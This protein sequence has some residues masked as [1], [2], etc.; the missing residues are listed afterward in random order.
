MTH[1]DPIDDFPRI[2]WGYSDAERL[3]L[4]IRSWTRNRLGSL[5]SLSS[6]RSRLSGWLAQRSV[7]PWHAVMAIM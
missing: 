4:N 3:E 7:S 1:P 5:Q 2:H 6:N